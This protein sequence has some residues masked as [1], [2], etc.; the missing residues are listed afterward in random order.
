MEELE[1]CVCTL[2]GDSD[3]STDLFCSKFR[4]IETHQL[5]ACNAYSKG[6]LLKCHLEKGVGV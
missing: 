5:L 6:K 1:T 3:G 4:E 2:Y